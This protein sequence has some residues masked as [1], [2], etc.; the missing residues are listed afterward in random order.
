MLDEKFHREIELENELI[1]TKDLHLELEH[2]ETV[3]RDKNTLSVEKLQHHIEQLQ[4]VKG[5]VENSGF[6]IYLDNR[7]QISYFYS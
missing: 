5:I 7:Y 3:L 6:S 4:N 1:I 2:H